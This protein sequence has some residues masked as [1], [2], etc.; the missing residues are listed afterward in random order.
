MKKILA[1][2]IMIFSFF[3]FL[4]L[5]V[6]AFSIN[7]KDW[8][9]NSENVKIP[10]C[11]PNSWQECGFEQWIKKSKEG[12]TSIE[13][14]KTAVDYIQDVILYIFGFLFFVTVLIIIWAWVTI[15]I[16]AWNDDKVENAKKIIINCIIWICVI[17]LAYPIAR[18]VIWTFDK[19]KTWQT[20][21]AKP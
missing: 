5:E 20:T 3:N 21:N 16:S 17:F 8:I 15:L 19:A 6:W 10:Y 7:Q 9:I 13:T 14:E 11:D 18:F 2:I 12:I 4:F 1:F